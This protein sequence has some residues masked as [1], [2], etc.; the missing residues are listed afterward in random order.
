MTTPFEGP[1]PTEAEQAMID[2]LRDI[3]DT[4]SGVLLVLTEMLEHWRMGATP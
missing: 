3:A 1:A 4:L 2:A